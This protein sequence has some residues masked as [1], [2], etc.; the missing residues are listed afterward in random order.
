MLAYVAMGVGCLF[1]WR[2]SMLGIAVFFFG[3]AYMKFSLG[4][5]KLD[6]EESCSLQVP[7]A[8]KVM[9][10]AYL[11]GALFFCVA[12]VSGESLNWLV[13]TF[14]FISLGLVYYFGS[15]SDSEKIPPWFA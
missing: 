13:G 2:G 4:A 11:L 12:S 5:I 6:D 14:L 15:K 7:R 8:M 3:K 9:G 1:A 10:L